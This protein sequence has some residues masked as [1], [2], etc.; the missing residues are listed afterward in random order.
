MLPV[1][2]AVMM[3]EYSREQK[4]SPDHP[5]PTQS[6]GGSKKRRHRVRRWL[7]FILLLL[8]ALVW[9]LPYIASTGAVSGLIVSAVNANMQEDVRIEGL[10]LSWLGP[11]R[12][13]GVTLRDREG[14]EIFQLA[15]GEFSK[16]I[17]GVLTSAESF[18]QVILDGPRGV[19]YVPESDKKQKG[20][21]GAGGQKRTTPTI[22]PAPHGRLTV[23]AGGLRM[24]QPDGREYA[25]KAIDAQLNL[26]T[27]DD[28]KG[29]IGLV[30]EDDGKVNGTVDI[31]HLVR[32][33]RV[34]LDEANGGFSLASIGEVNLGPLLEFAQP[35]TDAG[36][37]VQLS[38]EGSFA[39]GQVQADVSA[40]VNGLHAATKGKVGIHPI[41]L[42]YDGEIRSN[43]T[44]LNGQG[45]LKGDVGEL[46]TDL[47]YNQSHE[48]PKVSR[49]DLIAAVLT[50]K[51]IPL[52]DLSVEADG[53]LDLPALAAAVPALLKVRPD[54]QVTSGRVEIEKVMLR[55]GPDTMASGRVRIVD[56]AASQKDRAVALE[57]VSLDFDMY[58][59]PDTGLRINSA[60][61]N[62][63][64]A[65]MSAT[66]AP[67]KLA[68]TFSANLS[69][70]HQQ[71]N[72]ILDPPS[73]ELGGMING[74]LDVDRS[75]K[76]QV[77]IDLKI[78][79]DRI[80]YRMGERE[81][82]VRELQIVYKGF[83]SM[84]EHKPGRLVVNSAKANL[85]D[86]VIA[87]A[88]GWYDFRKKN[89]HAKL[90]L[91]Q[92][93]LAYMAQQT[94]LTGGAD[95]S[96]YAGTLELKAVVERAAAE[97]MIV[98]TGEGVIQDISID[99]RP[100]GTDAGED[101]R[102][103]WADLGILA[104]D[105]LF[106]VG[107]VMIGSGP[108]TIKG[109]DIRF[110]SGPQFKA[111]GQLEL[112]ADLKKCFAIGGRIARRKEPPDLAGQLTWSGNC[113]S[114]DEKVLVTGSG[115]IDGLQI[116][117]GR[118][119]VREGRLG[120]VNDIELD[121]KLETI[122]VKDFKIDSEILA[123][124]ITGKIEDYKS[125]CTLDLTGEYEGSWERIMALLHEIFPE[126][127]ETIHL[128]G[129]SQGT[130]RLT[131]PA[132][133]PE[134][135]PSY[136]DV[137]ATVSMA[138]A[139]GDVY[140]VKLGQALLSPRLEGGQ[141]LPGDA[142]IPA[143]D[144]RIFLDG[145]RVDL[146]T[147]EPTLETSAGVD[148]LSNV[149]IN[150]ILAR[151][152]LSR[153]NP[154]FA[155]MASMEGLV[156]LE[157]EDVSLPLSEKIKQRGQGRGHL[158][159][160]KLNFQ[161]E[162]LLAELMRLGGLDVESSQSMTVKGVDFSIAKGRINYDNFVVV[163]G[164]KFDLKFY[165]SVGFDDTL[166]LVVSLPIR[167][168]LLERFGVRGPVLDYARLLA[169]TRIDIPVIG[170]RL[171]PELDLSKVDVQPL[172][173]RVLGDILQ[174]KTQEVLEDILKPKK[175][176]QP[177]AA[178]EKTPKPSEPK[179]SENVLI[180]ILFDVLGQQDKDSKKTK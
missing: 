131:G 77:G 119:A 1:V 105:K 52:P 7:L 79:G 16:G 170:T 50:G 84:K 176:K 14:R 149:P 4:N 25:I 55:S 123:A 93:K 179:S 171:D 128:A 82:N 140:G 166:D 26:N 98:S 106:S 83:L 2:V 64:F 73:F 156:S 148:V 68:A 155:D 103:N 36:G 173:E 136:R 81:L 110:H 104:A 135:K 51:K 127:S 100:L 46:R 108:A 174:E 35:D 121:Q 152:L 153:V 54:L 6:A 180:D 40:R 57:P 145:V 159:L 87:G 33:G 151:H 109:K 101:V 86:E 162:G 32:N 90:Q 158:D 58:L 113:R 24:V 44:V 116:G 62:S 88:T 31:Q 3:N 15:R 63:A 72:Q 17:L 160:S 67:S 19:V 111:E 125:V 129:A 167:V 168:A 143:G 130:I 91:T 142:N 94:A 27:L 47:T 92:A 96:R 139:S 115:A 161:P 138:W 43:G 114:V 85:D 34:S 42:S 71:I 112:T 154:I 5:T 122:A 39:A 124:Q 146:R 78:I 49:D 147:E 75:D 9:S 89:L 66:G 23:H 141:I 132:H 8:I 13:T 56:V 18:G 30:L 74:G 59:E 165:G 38:V 48:W 137:E 70:L 134:I 102:L 177:G 163:F 60:T 150:R 69:Q 120:M 169:G 12:V 144:G 37:R 107:E 65:Q 175:S 45:M 10:W 126:T 20:D 22:L 99:G 61:L 118:K 172:I 53:K 80:Q 95:L 28:I 21:G 157:M 76:E 133:Q 41:D 178:D 117:Q 97:T 29:E 164:D 11:C